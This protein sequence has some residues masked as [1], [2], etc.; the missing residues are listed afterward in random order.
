MGEK[1]K[2]QGPL[3]TISDP[4]RSGRSKKSRPREIKLFFLE[5]TFFREG[6]GGEAHYQKEERKR[7]SP[8]RRQEKDSAVWWGGTLN[9]GG[10]KGESNRGAAA[11]KR[12]K[13]S[14]LK[15]PK[16]HA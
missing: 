12:G 14:G 4:R 9:K 16:E 15:K 11:G 3:T 13:I 10:E 5:T 7:S 2:K 8:M 6:E 1:K